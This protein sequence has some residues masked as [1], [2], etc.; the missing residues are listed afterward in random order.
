MQ[1]R[2]R[3]AEMSAESAYI[4]PL[5]AWPPAPLVHAYRAI[6][7]ATVWRGH[8]AFGRAPLRAGRPERTS[9]FDPN[10]GDRLSGDVLV[11]YVNRKEIAIQHYIT[12]L[13]RV[14]CL[15]NITE[16]KR[17]KRVVGLVRLVGS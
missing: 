17:K 5:A 15:L 8:E 14:L 3:V 13:V 10:H 4:P 9:C 16:E 12:Y 1:P 2:L 11:P 6:S 7:V